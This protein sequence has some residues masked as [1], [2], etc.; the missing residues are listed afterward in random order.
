VE[1]KASFAHNRSYEPQQ[2]RQKTE[3]YA[4]QLHWM[5]SCLTLESSVSERTNVSISQPE[6]QTIILI[7]LAVL[8]LTNAEIS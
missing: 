2:R 3:P 6:A 1:S 4:K 7:S 5:N 8:P